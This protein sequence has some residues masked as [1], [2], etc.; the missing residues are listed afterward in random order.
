MIAAIPPVRA[1]SDVDGVVRRVKQQARAFTRLTIDERIDLLTTIRREYH[2]LAE[3]SVRAACRAK[4]IDPSG[5]RAGEEWLAGPMIV[6]RNL[7]LLE[8]SLGEVRRHGAPQIPRS[9][10]RTLPD[11]RLAIRVFPANKTESVLLPNH[12]VEVYLQHGVTAE[13]LRERQASFYRRPHDGRLCAVLGA[14]NVNAIPPTDALYKMFVEGAVCVLKMNPVNEYLGPFIERAFRGLID[15]GFFAV[16]YGGPEV[17]R[18]LVEHPLTDEIHMTGSDRTHDAIVW[19]PTGGE[20]DERRLRNEPR[21][22]KEISSE[23]GNI[24][25]VIVVPGPYTESELRYQG[26]NIAGMVANNASFN[27]TAAKLLVVPKAWGGREALLEAIERALQK[28]APRKAYYPGAEER[29]R[30]FTESRN[31]VRLV[32]APNEGELAYAI[33]PDVDPSHA[34]EPAFS[35]EPWC[36]ILTETRLEGSDAREFLERAVRFLNDRVWGTLAA[37]LIV[38][39][40]AL[41]DS[42]VG[43]AVEKAIRDLRYGTVVVNSWAGAVFGLGSTPWGAHP[44]STLADIQ[45]GRGWVHNTFMLEG[46]EKTVMRA[47]IRSFPPPPWF[48]GHRTLNA[49]ARKL[50]DFEMAPS[51]LKIPSIAATAMRG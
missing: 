41:A 33:L 8:E 25:P 17:G 1:T 2:Q 13:N 6:I 19:G 49:L 21:I 27:C 42:N 10:M 5:S 11:G 45:S 14:G 16:V 29:W 48:P 31:G 15:R 51:W 37:H 44:S 40:S 26:E 24:T 34:E 39:P 35:R 28:D 36:A 3:E 38:H 22:R 43:S 12:Q 50:V 30:R 32:G 7:R 9:W 46:I 23:L 18:A 20:G 4:G 47:P